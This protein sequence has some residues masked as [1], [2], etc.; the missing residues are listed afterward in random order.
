MIKN[1]LLDRDRLAGK[2]WRR[3]QGYNF[4]AYDALAPVGGSEFAHAVLAMPIGFIERSGHYV[5]V[6]LMSLSSG[7]N[8]FVGPTGQWLASY[9]PAVLRTYPFSLVRVE[10]SE[11]TTVCVDESSGLIV[12]EG[13]E[14]VERFFEPD[15]TPSAT[16]KIVTELLRRI[17]HD[18]TITDLAVAALAE[19]GV[20]KPWQ[21]AVPVGNQQ[22]SVGGLHCVD[23]T[24][25]NALDDAAFLKLRKASSLII[26]HGQ[27]LSMG[28]VNILARLNAFQ[29]QSV[30]T[31]QR[32]MNML[33]S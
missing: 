17:E 8:A 13:G 26:A 15:G 32:T 30:Q 4:A 11:Q 20:I 3:P 23:E 31:D 14:N 27:L 18:Q 29:Q 10:G 21:L 24:A 1:V 19:A 12:N 7:S 9:V 6:G 16:T 2:G 25:L 28:Q 22:I 33:R 5:P